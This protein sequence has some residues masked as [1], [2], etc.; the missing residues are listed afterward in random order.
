MRSVHH[1]AVNSENFKLFRKV[2]AEYEAEHPNVITSHSV[3][4]LGHTYRI[5]ATEDITAVFRAAGLFCTTDTYPAVVQNTHVS[6]ARGH[7]T[8]SDW[9]EKFEKRLDALDERL[10][11]IEQRLNQPDSQQNR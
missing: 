1:V 8:D 9:F 6:K 7:M 5:S 10:R 11:N 4:F 3:G 2:L